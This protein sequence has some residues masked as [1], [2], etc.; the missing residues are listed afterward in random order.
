MNNQVMLS[1]EDLDIGLVERIEVD[2]LLEAIYRLSGFDFRMYMK[3]S[4]IRRIQNRMRL[5]RIG[6]ITALQEKNDS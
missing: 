5:E 3:S 6:T 1:E 2:L 4:I